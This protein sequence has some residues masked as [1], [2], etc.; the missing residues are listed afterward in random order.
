MDAYTTYITNLSN[1]R[2]S[3]LRREAAEYALSRAARQRRG[4]R[5][6]RFRDQLL[7][8]RAPAPEPVAPIARPSFTAGADTEP[9]MPLRRSA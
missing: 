7:R 2:T 9:L 4:S 6:G 3:E 1:A 5:W 8:R